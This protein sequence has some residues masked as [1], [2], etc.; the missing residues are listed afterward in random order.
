MVA[1][2]PNGLIKLFVDGQ[3]VGNAVILYGYYNPGYNGNIPLSSGTGALAGVIRSHD[4]G[5]SWGDI[6]LILTKESSLLYEETALAVMDKNLQAFVR[7]EQQNV[8]QYI[9]TDDGYS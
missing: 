9:S 1:Y 7:T 4:N 2:F 3:L 5:E 6:S 8:V